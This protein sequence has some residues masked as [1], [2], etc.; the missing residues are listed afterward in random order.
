SG[1]PAEVATVIASL[2]APGAGYITGQVVVVDGGN[3]IAEE[4]RFARG[5]S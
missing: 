5:D 3:A 2:A 4:R 1:N